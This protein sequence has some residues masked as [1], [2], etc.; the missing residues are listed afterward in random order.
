MNPSTGG[1]TPCLSIPCT[2]DRLRGNLRPAPLAFASS[3]PSSKRRSLNNTSLEFAFALNVARRRL[4]PPSTR[5]AVDLSHRTLVPPS[6]SL[7][8]STPPSHNPICGQRSCELCSKSGPSS[9]SGSIQHPRLVPPSTRPAVHPS[10]R[11]LVP[12]STGPAVELSHRRLRFCLRLRPHIPSVAG[13][14]ASCVRSPGRQDISGSIRRPRLRL[15]SVTREVVSCIRRSDPI[16]EI[17]LVGFDV[18]H[19]WRSPSSCS[20]GVRPLQHP[21]YAMT[22]RSMRPETSNFALD[23]DFASTST[24]PSTST[25]TSPRTST[26]PSTSTLT[27]TST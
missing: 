17:A 4:V 3:G 5:P 27:S 7:S 13:E 18:V 1:S 11:P 19:L 15:S 8:L 9:F 12:P 25:S 6:T 26:S 21:E 20:L 10:H 2:S 14:V 22:H 24:S 23:L 16:L